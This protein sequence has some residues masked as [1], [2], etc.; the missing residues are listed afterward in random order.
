ME[1]GGNAPIRGNIDCATVAIIREGESCFLELLFYDEDEE[2]YT[3][4]IVF[5]QDIAS[6]V[7][8]DAKFDINISL[9][10]LLHYTDASLN[11]AEILFE[12]AVAQH[13]TLEISEYE[14]RM[15][16]GQEFFV[17]VQTPFLCCEQCFS[18]EKMSKVVDLSTVS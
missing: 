10:T 8:L 7:R 14:E 1:I 13:G 4:R 17:K 16:E 9:E 11:F 15:V 3:T 2:L 6:S 5:E 18:L 12:L